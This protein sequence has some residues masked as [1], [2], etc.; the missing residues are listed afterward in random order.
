[1]KNLKNRTNKPQHK[2]P[3]N[4]D[5]YEA[6]SEFWDSHDISDYIDH[7]EEVTDIEIKLNRKFFRI[8][9]KLE[10]KI[11]IKAR[12]KG[13]TTESLINLWLN[14]KLNEFEKLEH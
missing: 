5:S 2:I 4:F 8:E 9:K 13:V 7:T 12:E 14:E 3:K 11:S 10:K 6:A 1:M